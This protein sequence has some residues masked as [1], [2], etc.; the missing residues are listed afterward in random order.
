MSKLTYAVCLYLDPDAPASLAPGTPAGDYRLANYQWVCTSQPDAP[1][2]SSWV[3]AADNPTLDKS[4]VDC[5]SFWAVGPYDSNTDFII[6]WQAL[7]PEGGHASPI[8]P[9]SSR[10]VLEGGD[11]G[12]GPGITPP[13]FDTPQPGKNAWYFGP[14]P[15]VWGGGPERYSF[16][17]EAKPGEDSRFRKAFFFVDP[18]METDPNG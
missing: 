11:K 4:K 1:A 8:D 3:G 10:T 2:N 16:T 18:E 9:H 13:G 15:I 12:V 17:V 7:G 14:T 5:L 6:E